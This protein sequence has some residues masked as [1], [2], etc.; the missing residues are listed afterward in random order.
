ML[1]RSTKEG[2]SALD[3]SC[4][5]PNAYIIATVENEKMA[6][7]LALKWGVY[8]KVVGVSKNTDDLVSDSVKAAKEILNLKYKDLVCVVGSVPEEA[9][10]NFLK[11]E[12]I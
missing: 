2:K 4:L 3:V 12:E 1:F 8:T 11:I 6:R 5:R 9:H 10:T 7:M